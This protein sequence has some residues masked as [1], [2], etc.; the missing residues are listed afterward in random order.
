VSGFSVTGGGHLRVSGLSIHN[1]DPFSPTYVGDL[2]QV[3]LLDFPDSLRLWELWYEQ[4]MFSGKLSFKFG[5]MAIDQDFIVP[6]YYLSLAR[7]IS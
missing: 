5:Q 6:E 1:G 7:S 4:K 2:N 3:S